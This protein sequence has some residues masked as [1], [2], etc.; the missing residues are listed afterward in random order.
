MDY[1]PG[2]AARQRRHSAA[3]SLTHPAESR[4]PAAACLL[5]IAG[6]AMQNNNICIRQ[7]R[8]QGHEGLPAEFGETGALAD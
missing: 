5:K 6:S 1:V 4:F 3:S 7:T 8:L 2:I